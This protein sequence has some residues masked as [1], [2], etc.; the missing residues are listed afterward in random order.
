M[1]LIPVDISYSILALS[2]DVA[3][4]QAMYYVVVR[5][6]HHHYYRV[7]GSLQVSHIGRK[8]LPTILLLI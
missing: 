6:S 8:K 7:C 3:Y 2:L 1:E 4:D 5:L